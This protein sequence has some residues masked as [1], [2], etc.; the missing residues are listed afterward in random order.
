MYPHM[1]TMWGGLLG[2]ICDIICMQILSL[3]LT[4]D[5]EECPGTALDGPGL[6]SRTLWT[7]SS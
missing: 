7:N 6:K 1:K 2:C 3:F 5:Q 4:V